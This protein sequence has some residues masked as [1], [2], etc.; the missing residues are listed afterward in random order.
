[1]QKLKY[2]KVVST[3][4]GHTVPR[5][6]KFVLVM[7]V[8]LVGIVPALAQNGRASI[9]LITP[10]YPV[11]VEATFDVIIQVETGGLP[12][13][14]AAAYLNFDPAIFRVERIQPGTSLPIFLQS[15]MDNTNG[16]VNFAAGQL[17]PAFPSG[18][19]TLATV[20]LRALAPSDAA[21]ITLSDELA[22]DTD[23]VAG[24]ASVIGSAI[25]S[26]I[27]VSIDAPVQPENLSAPR[28]SI[29]QPLTGI[30][31]Q[32]LDPAAVEDNALLLETLTAPVA[33]NTT[34]PNAWIADAGWALSV[35]EDGATGSWAFSTGSTS[36]ASLSALR[37]AH[38]IDL[39]A[40]VSPEVAFSY[41]LSGTTLGYIEVSIG[42]DSGW[43]KIA[44]VAPAAGATQLVDLSAYAGQ[45][46]QL[47]FT[48]ESAVAGDGWSIDSLSIVDGMVVTE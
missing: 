24:G 14:A 9:T 43:T 40:V 47:R 48:L 26:L 15:G 16:R 41:S 36:T 13:D 42:S 2:T 7:A 44:S 21:L 4:R 19:F 46:V 6:F 18:T 8:L 45:T 20:T 37:L 38:P 33:L 30:E 3:K 29:V 39:S 23:V 25:G 12:V 31:F 17:P 22:R 32:A 10:N 35:S 11:A 5:F 28:N 27:T 34:L 1:M